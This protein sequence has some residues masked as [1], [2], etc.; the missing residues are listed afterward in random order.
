MGTRS[1]CHV[2]TVTCY[3]AMTNSVPLLLHFLL[4]HLQTYVL[5]MKQSDTIGAVRQHLNKLRY[6]LIAHYL[7][8][9]ICA[10]LMNSCC[11]T[12]VYRDD[13]AGETR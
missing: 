9:F 1:E 10:L 8:T 3:T 12:S 13:I 7:M 5:K 2:D 6:T 11:V 4:P